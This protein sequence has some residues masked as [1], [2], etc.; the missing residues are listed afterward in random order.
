MDEITG[1]LAAGQVWLLLGGPGQGRTTLSVQWATVIARSAHNVHLVTPREPSEWVASRVLSQTGR[2]PVHRLARRDVGADHE[3]RLLE[4]RSKMLGLPMA[5][6][7]A[8]H[9]AYVPET[10]PCHAELHPHAVVIDDA[11]LASGAT[12]EWA[13]KCAAAGTLVILS[14]PRH[15]VALGD[16]DEAPLEPAWARAAD[17][18]V[19]V[20][21]LGLRDGV[22][23]PGEAELVVLKNRWGYLRTVCIMIQ[24]HY[25]RFVDVAH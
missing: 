14:L 13:A 2:I 8:G 11:D 9:Q 23:R 12:P 19:D 3:E 16:S 18:I 22:I 15:L 20:R 25:A 5:V 4:T 10:D 7:P 21:H 17:V 24:A 1:G 6:W